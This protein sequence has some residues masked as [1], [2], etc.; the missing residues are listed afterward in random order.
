MVHMISDFGGVRSLSGPQAETASPVVAPPP[1]RSPV[2]HQRQPEPSYHPGIQAPAAPTCGPSSA[3]GQYGIPEGQSLGEVASGTRAQPFDVTLSQLA[4]AVYGTRGEP[5][6][7]WTAVTDAQLIEKGIE[8]PAAWR[9][10]YLAGG[11]ELIEQEFAAEIYTDGNGNYVLAYRGTAEGVSDWVNNFAQA[12]GFETPGGVDKFSGLAVRTAVEFEAVFGNAQ[13][14]G[15]STNLA[16]TGHSQGGGLAAAGSLASGIPAVTFMASGLHP[17][18]LARVGDGFTPGEAR[19]IAEGGQIRNHSLRDDLLTNVQEGTPGLSTL[20]PSALGTSIV[21]HP[22]PEAYHALPGYVM[23]IEDRA[24]GGPGLSQ[25]EQDRV[26][27]AFA[28]D[29][30]SFALYRSALS[31]SPNALTDAMIEQAPWQDGYENPFQ[32]GKWLDD[33]VPDWVNDLGTRATHVVV[34]TAID[35][36]T[37]FART[38]AAAGEAVSNYPFVPFIGILPPS[39]RG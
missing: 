26:N 2:L 14:H 4:T 5:P 34:R 3:G 22:G 33:K 28:E 31:H 37:G 10:Q 12:T 19:D 39:R 30:A 16:L 15:E 25:Q 27:R 21:V 11:D 8:D 13:G 29:P 9:E 32:L 38:V 24:S 36:V 17:N 6:C 18:T 23:D 7:G 35:G 1:A 20:A